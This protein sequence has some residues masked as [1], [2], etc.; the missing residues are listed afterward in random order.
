MTYQ[1]YE[2]STFNGSPLELFKFTSDVNVYAY[3]NNETTVSH[4]GTEYR[5]LPI[6][7]GKIAQ[8][9]SEAP[10]LLPVRLPRDCDVAA[11]FGP[12]LPA[13]PVGLTVFRRHLNDPDVQ[14]VP[15]FLGTVAT[16]SFEEDEAILSGYSLLASLNRRVPWLT[17]QPNCNWALYHYG[18]VA[19]RNAFRLDGV[20]ASVSGLTLNAVVFSTQPD[21][22][23]KAAWVQRENTREVR[24]ITSH[25]GND[26]TLQS[27]FPGLAVGEPI[28]AFAGCMRDMAT[29]GTKFGNLPRFAGWPD[30]PSKNPYRDN[31]YGSAGKRSAGSSV[32]TS[33]GAGFRA[34]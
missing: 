27:P 18:C 9:S 13:K 21:G 11:L 4:L 29:C 5:P 2:E 16:C 30:I 14:F 6:V 32:T 31:V 17:Y 25:V 20:V 22:W 3:T 1:A 34:G 26:I 23:L 28:V 24:F 12:F 33:T 10:S 8:N 19:D 7:R 15:I